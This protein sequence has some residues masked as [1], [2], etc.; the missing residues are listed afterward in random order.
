[1]I[2]SGDNVTIKIGGNAGMVAMVTTIIITNRKR[3]YVELPSGEITSYFYN[4]LKIV[5]K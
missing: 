2:K 5:K 1:M 3:F 4:Q